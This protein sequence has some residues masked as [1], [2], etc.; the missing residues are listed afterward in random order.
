[1]TTNNM[2]F[3]AAECLTEEFSSPKTELTFPIEIEQLRQG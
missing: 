2:N 3:F 1:M